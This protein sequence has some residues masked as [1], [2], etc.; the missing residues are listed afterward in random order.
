[1]VAQ[2]HR[3]IDDARRDSIKVR[4]LLLER[5]V[6]AIC[7]TRMLPIGLL[8]E[9][10]TGPLDPFHALSLRIFCHLVVMP[11]PQPYEGQKKNGRGDKFRGRPIRL[12][13]SAHALLALE[14]LCREA[15]RI[16]AR[17]EIRV[18]GGDCRVEVGPCGDRLNAD[19]IGLRLC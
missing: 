18:I 6:E 2:P 8:I 7:G 17:L 4:F 12:H 1:M 3:A 15:A 16:G 13:P 9:A 11:F 14:S 19:R 5:G 10:L